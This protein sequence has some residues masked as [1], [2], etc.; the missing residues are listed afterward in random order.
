MLDAPGSYLDEPP[1]PEPYC[2]D[3]R[4]SGALF[5]EQFLLAV[6]HDARVQA[7]KLIASDNA[8]RV[9]A[10][11]PGCAAALTWSADFGPDFAD[12][13]TVDDD[14]G[15]NVASGSYPSDAI[16]VLPCSM[17]TLARIANGIASHHRT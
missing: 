1:A 10:E 8:L 5:F 15:A 2:R 13:A 6:E 9:M 16:V 7:V 14:I 12:S 3:T 11:E 17:G 4:A